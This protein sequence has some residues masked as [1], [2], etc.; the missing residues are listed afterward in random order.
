[1]TPSRVD[2]TGAVL[3][4][5]AAMAKVEAVATAME[6]LSTTTTAVVEAVMGAMEMAIS[7][8]ERLLPI[9][10]V[11]RPGRGVREEG[12]DYLIG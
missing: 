2:A 9:T 10:M 7:R 4:A 5:A 12:I 3:L 6:T 1:M 8:A 11:V